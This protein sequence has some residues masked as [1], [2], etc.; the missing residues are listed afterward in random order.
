MVK[1]EKS[2]GSTVSWQSAES[3]LVPPVESV[4]VGYGGEDSASV[5]E[6]PVTAGPLVLAVGAASVAADVQSEMLLHCAARFPTYVHAWQ[7]EDIDLTEDETVG[8]IVDFGTAV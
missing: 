2:S 6:A 5:G 8:S 7:T 1:T 3:A 4:D